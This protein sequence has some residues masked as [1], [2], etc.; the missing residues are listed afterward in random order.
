MTRTTHARP[1]PF[2]LALV[3]ACTVHHETQGGRDPSPAGGSTTVVTTLD[4]QIREDIVVG[5]GARGPLAT[6]EGQAIA[7]PFIGRAGARVGVRVENTPHFASVGIR[8]PVLA[9]QA[10]EDAPMLVGGSANASA[11]LPADGVYLAVVV[12]LAWPRSTW[13]GPTTS[14]PS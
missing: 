14:S 5:S 13:T 4:L 6:A 12:S 2:A 7:H 8:G 11:E 1:I 9:G 10:P 3:A